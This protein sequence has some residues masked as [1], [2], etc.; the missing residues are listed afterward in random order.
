MT[1]LNFNLLTGGVPVPLKVTW[2]I[3]DEGRPFT[4][5]VLFNLCKIFQW[6]EGSELIIIE[7]IWPIKNLSSPSPIYLS[8]LF[9]SC[10]FSDRISPK[11]Y[12]YL[13]YNLSRFPVYSSIFLYFSTII[14][15]RESLP[16]PVYLSCN[17][18]SPLNIWIFFYFSKFKKKRMI[19]WPLIRFQNWWE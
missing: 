15:A 1:L 7:W 10:N 2:L 12:I 8:F 5:R 6:I 4:R 13:S 16:P 9:F 11:P 3:N 18:S 19:I 17:L 14:S